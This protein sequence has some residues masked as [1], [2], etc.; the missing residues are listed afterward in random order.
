MDLNLPLDTLLQ[1]A[2]LAGLIVAA[3]MRLAQRLTK[4]ET[5]MNVI[6]KVIG[7]RLRLNG[8]GASG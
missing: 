2:F 4:L 5:R 1:T 7:E 8:P 3:W 6:W